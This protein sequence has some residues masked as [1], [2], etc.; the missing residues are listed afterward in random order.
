M[1][2]A[3]IPI[4]IGIIMAAG[5][6][7]WIGR[8][9]A[10]TQRTHAADTPPAW[11]ANASPAAAQ[12]EQR[13]APLVRQQI[14]AVRAEQAVLAAMLPDMRFTGEQVLAQVDTTLQSHATLVKSVGVHLA[15]LHGLLPSPEGRRLMSS[16]ADSLQGRVQK[17]Y[18]WRGGAQDQDEGYMGGRHGGTGRGGAGQGAGY[19]RQYRGGRGGGG[20]LALRLQLTHEQIAW[21]QLRDPDFEQECLSLRER[22]YEAH[23]DLVASFENAQIAEEELTARL[24]DLVAVHAA[25]EKRV[26]Q[27]IVLLR[28]L[29]SQEQQDLL[30]GLCRGRSGTNGDRVSSGHGPL[31]I[32][33][34]SSCADG[35]LT[36]FLNRSR[37]RW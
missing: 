24:D 35:P 21:V 17:R 18:R 29:L 14:D 32:L 19:G 34:L 2:R 33:W 4:L 30:S 3:K 28:P 12:A 31:P 26:A 25:L 37:D 36:G 9:V 15:Y 8:A 5:A 11:L 10:T 7:F 13:F 22:L 20:G 6:A 23:T 16:C 27:H 1:S